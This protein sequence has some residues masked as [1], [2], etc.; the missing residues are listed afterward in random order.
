MALF[1]LLS[2]SGDGCG[3]WM[4]DD[5]TNAATLAPPSCINV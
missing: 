2:L 5:G 3:G 4:G 1:S